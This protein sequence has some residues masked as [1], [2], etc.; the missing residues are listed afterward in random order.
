MH[1]FLQAKAFGRV[2]GP[3]P[4]S[5]DAD[6]GI[7]YDAT[8][9]TSKDILAFI[10]FCMLYVLFNLTVG[11]TLMTTSPFAL[12]W[13]LKEIQGRTYIKSLYWSSVFTG[14]LYMVVYLIVRIFLLSRRDDVVLHA[15]GDM[16]YKLNDNFTIISCVVPLFLLLAHV[17]TAVSSSKTVP[18]VVIV[19]KQVQ[20]IIR[21]FCCQSCTHVLWTFS[22]WVVLAWLQLIAVSFIPVVISVLTDTFRSMALFG[23]LFSTIAC[24]VVS[25]A[26]LIQICRT[27]QS[28]SKCFLFLSLAASLCGCLTVAVFTVYFLVLTEEGLDAD[29]MAGYVLSL[30]PSLALAAIAYV[31]DNFL[32]DSD[33]ASEGKGKKSKAARGF[34]IQSNKKENMEEEEDED[35]ND[36]SD[37]A[38]ITLGSSRHEDEM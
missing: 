7:V 38:M 24:V 16:I 1:L 13:F 2:N 28:H 33:E 35:K 19:P 15:K 20:H 36:G 31:A 29:S 10:L 18:S 23:L 21:R 12:K 5:D 27:T 34:N 11:T 6:R 8:T 30:I 37:E 4:Y 26:V 3:A 25:G 14:V 22:L 32:M 17:F 9:F